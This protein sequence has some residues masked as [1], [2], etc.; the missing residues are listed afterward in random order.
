[1]RFGISGPL[2]Y[3]FNGAEAARAAKLLQAD[4]I[5]P[6]HYDGWEHFRE[7]R[8]QADAAFGKAGLAERVR[9]LPRGVRTEIEI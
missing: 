2:R 1:M 3:T 7:P 6:L 4:T 5:V 9:W 8:D